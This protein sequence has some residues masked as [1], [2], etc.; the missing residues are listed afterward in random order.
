MVKASHCPFVTERQTGKLGI[1]VFSLWFDL[2]GNQT[3]IYS[4]GRKRTIH[5]TTDRL[6]VIL[7]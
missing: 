1:L 6:L 3:R 4:F 2:A 7:V 5:S